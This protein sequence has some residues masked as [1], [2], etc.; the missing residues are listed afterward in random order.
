MVTYSS[1]LAWKIPWTEEPGGLQSMGSQRV[2]Q[3]RATSLSLF[4]FM[5]WRRKWQPILVFLPEQSQGS[6]SLVACRLR[7]HTELD[8]TEVTSSSRTGFGSTFLMY[9]S[10]SISIAGLTDCP[11]N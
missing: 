9:V 11:I 5:H 6:R 4:T 2:G 3:D 8:M 7:G 1:T 10:S